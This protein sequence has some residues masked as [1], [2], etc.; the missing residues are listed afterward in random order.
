[1]SVG[2]VMTLM[3]QLSCYCLK[4][5][6]LQ[7]IE[8]EFD[9][10]R[11]AVLTIIGAGN[12]IMFFSPFGTLYHITLTTHFASYAGLMA[13]DAVLESDEV[14]RFSSAQ[15]TTTLCRLTKRATAKR[16]KSTVANMLDGY[17]RQSRMRW[18]MLAPHAGEE[19]GSDE[20][21]GSTPAGSAI[22]DLGHPLAAASNE[23]TNLT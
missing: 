21:D 6:V 9:K 8:N 14:L 11:A 17:A 16:D 4:H 19:A 15:V 20:G 3:L 7:P 22:G 2:A 1:M 18:R 5:G 10:W 12:L 13:D 23:D